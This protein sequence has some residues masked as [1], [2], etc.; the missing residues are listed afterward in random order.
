[1][2]IIEF[3]LI[4][5]GVGSV[6][7]NEYYNDIGRGRRQ[8]LQYLYFNEGFGVGKFNEYRYI[9]KTHT[10]KKTKNTVRIILLGDSY[11]ESFQIFQRDH[12][13]VIAKNELEDKYQNKKFEILNLG[14][15]G[16]D[17]A[18]M[19]A[20]QKLLAEKFNPD[21]IFYILSREDLKP[22]YSDPL[23]PKTVLVGDSLK[24]K[25]DTNQKKINSFN[26]NKLFIQHSTILN[27]LN[28]GIKKTKNT[29]LPSILLG[30]LYPLETTKNEPIMKSSKDDEKNEVTKTI[31]E[32]FNSKRIIIINRDI[33]PLPDYFYKLLDIKGVN[34]YE[35]GTSLNKLLESG[36]DPNYWK[37]TDKSG[38]WN[39]KGHEVV[40]RKL[41]NII[42][43]LINN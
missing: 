4:Y 37:I 36:V 18:D 14:R 10:I 30:K 9:G 43:Q 13:S 39:Q 23:R 7:P 25:L 16:F 22:K 19:Y 41:A 15:S 21:Y 1:M 38:H 2:V 24:I 35:F 40:G 26:R 11:V 5:S 8:N 31:I 6:S 3:F 28:L 42:N 17:I 20:Y 32:N 33:P 34:H 29:P 27:M 12:F